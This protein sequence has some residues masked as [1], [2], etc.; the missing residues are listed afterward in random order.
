MNPADSKLPAGGPGLL[1]KV[2]TCVRTRS[3]AE[4]LRDEILRGGYE[5]DA[6]LTL[7]RA[8]LALLGD[9]AAL[10]TLPEPQHS[11]AMEVYRRLKA[12]YIGNSE[13]RCLRTATGGVARPMT[14][15]PV[16]GQTPGAIRGM[17][18]LEGLIR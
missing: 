1:A 13:C 16:H 7:Y 9:T 12:Q 5:K 10:T 17:R 4:S 11:V 6:L 2:A 3:D 15:C 14:T 8:V 18:N